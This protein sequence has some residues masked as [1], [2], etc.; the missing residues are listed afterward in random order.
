MSFS[1]AVND[2]ND[3][4]LGSDGNLST[5]TELAATLQACE[6]AARTLL[7]EKIYAVDEGIPNFDVV[8]SGTPN[9]VQ[10]E[11]YLRRALLSVE[12]VTQLVD[13]S[14]TRAGNSLPY[15]ATIQTVY[16]TGVISG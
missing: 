14:V 7:A 3:I 9:L 5:T 6:H 2:R 13:V 4:F 8:W 16:G 10:F 11:A 12:G 15:S 1:L